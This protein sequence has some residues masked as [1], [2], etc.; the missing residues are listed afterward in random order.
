LVGI[1]PGIGSSNT[2]IVI[3]EHLKNPDIIRV[4]YAEE[5]EKANLKILLIYVMIFTESIIPKLD[6]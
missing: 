2:G 5:F 1:D 6:S 4:V 3:N